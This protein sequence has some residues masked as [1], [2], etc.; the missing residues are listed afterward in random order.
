MVRYSTC[1]AWS[2]LDRGH[3][4][5]HVVSCRGKTWFRQD[6]SRTWMWPGDLK[7]FVNAQVERE[8]IPHLYLARKWDISTAPELNGE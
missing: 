1:D 7:S 5:R 8:H 4:R 2:L 3:R 6:T